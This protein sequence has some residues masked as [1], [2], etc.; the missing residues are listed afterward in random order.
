MSTE[1]ELL[2]EE[3]MLLDSQVYDNM[4]VIPL[5]MPE[6]NI[7]LMS[8]EKGLELGLVKITESNE[9]GMVNEVK[10]INNAVTSLL[11]L[12]G[13]QIIGSKQN[14]IANATIIIS[15]KSEKV[16]PVSCTEAG[17]WS[18]NSKKFHYSNHMASSRV[19]RD[20]S[21]SVLKSLREN[22]T[23][24]SDQNEVWNNISI[25]SNE[26][27][28][29]SNTSALEDTYKERSNDIEKYKKA[30]KIQE[31][32]N[33]L[34]VYINGQLVGC[35]ILYNSPKYREYHEKIVESYILDALARNDEEYANNIEDTEFFLDRIKYY[36]Y[37][38]YASVDLG[39]DYRMNNG[40]ITGSA[41][42]Y[43]DNLINASFFI[44]NNHEIN[45]D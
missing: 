33:G 42:V 11:I 1:L 4:T 41:M 8:L 44:N 14:R 37:E 21:T 34:I 29:Q 30:F 23:F 35:E 22:N 31:K 24:Q 5:T 28:V 10:V 38:T 19:R 20:K 45:V 40:N 26:L 39:V 9:A 27:R 6:S 2:F 15:A 43:E 13:E 36:D 12:D 16:I 17:R 3:I 32:Q 7:D 18:Y 25:V